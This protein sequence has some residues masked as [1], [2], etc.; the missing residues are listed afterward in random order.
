M[1]YSHWLL[2]GPKPVAHIVEALQHRGYPV[3]IVIVGTG[4]YLVHTNDKMAKHIERAID[5]ITS[6]I[7]A[8]NELIRALDRNGREK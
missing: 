7:T 8:Y 3:E 2:Y 1:L 4:E 6:G 5:H